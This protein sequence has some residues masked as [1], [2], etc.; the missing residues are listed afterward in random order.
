MTVDLTIQQMFPKIY[1]ISHRN[2][3]AQ[4]VSI[5]MLCQ[6]PTFEPGIYFLIDEH[7]R[8]G[9]VG[10]SMNVL[11]RMAGHVDKGAKRVRMIP[12]CH[13]YQVALEKMF[14]KLIDPPQN[15]NLRPR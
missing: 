8:I 6:E 5:L 2:E 9:Y 12:C 15:W 14:I 11:Q 7:G 3:P 4:I 1:E 10:R 13:S